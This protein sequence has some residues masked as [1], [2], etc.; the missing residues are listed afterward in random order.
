MMIVKRL[1]TIIGASIFATS[2]G[3]ASIVNAMEYNPKGYN[4]LIPNLKGMT[5]ANSEYEDVTDKIPSDETLIKTY[6]S[7][8]T[9]VNTFSIDDKIF[10]YEI[11]NRGEKAYV[12]IDKDGKGIFTEKHNYD[13]II[14]YV[15]EWLIEK[16]VTLGIKEPSKQKEVKKQPTSTAKTNIQIKGV[17]TVEIENALIAATNVEN[18]FNRPKQFKLTTEQEKILQKTVKSIIATKKAL[19]LVGSKEIVVFNQEP[20]KQITLESVHMSEP[21]FAIIEYNNRRAIGSSALLKTGS[22]NG[23]RIDLNEHVDGETI[24]VRL[25]KDDGDGVYDSTKDKCMVDNNGMLIFKQIK[26]GTRRDLSHVFYSNYLSRGVPSL[27]LK[28]QLPGTTIKFS[29]IRF[30]HKNPPKTNFFIVIRKDRNGFP[31]KIIGVS[32]NLRGGRGGSKITLQEPTSNETLYAMVYQDNG[33]G[34][35]NENEDIPLRGLD[36]LPIIVKFQVVK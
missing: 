25:Y 12:L 34:T 10:A 8:N 16:R 6:I 2:I 24:I 14:T 1:V 23:V 22:T 30:G 31:G 29:S 4:H 20:G 18:H 19:S 9:A 7:K 26:I 27:L 28:E 33:N 15:P 3:I 11:R 17:T 35:F 32:K 5:L 36:N 13:E 21:G